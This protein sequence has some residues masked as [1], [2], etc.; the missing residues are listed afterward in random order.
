MSK[1]IFMMLVISLLTFQSFGQSPSALK[2]ASAGV[3]LT[4]QKVSYD[5]QYFK[6]S[7][8]NGD[9]PANKGVCTDVII[10]AYR[11]ALQVDLQKDVHEDMKANFK[12]YPKDWGRKTTD[13]NID[14]R[15]VYN[16]MVFFKRKG[17]AKPITKLADDYK[18]GDIVCWNLSGNTSHIGLVINQKSADGK[19]YLIVHNI[20]AGQVIEDV[21]FSWKIIGHYQYRVLY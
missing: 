13:A 20:G 21:L 3:Q 9:V 7:Y 18:P 12:L 6:I 1:K 8:P 2:L 14:H 4:K 5:P 10:R 16:L 11:N 17:T 15:R 19:R